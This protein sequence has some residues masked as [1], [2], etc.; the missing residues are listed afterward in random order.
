MVIKNKNKKDILSNIV[1]IPKTQKRVFWAREFKILND[2][3]NLFP[4][5]SFW[6][7]I[8]FKEKKD[9]LIF[10]K[11]E[12]GIKVLKTLYNEYNYQPRVT[13]K[14]ELGEKFGE[15]KIVSS[16]RNTIKNFLS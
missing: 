11:S 15:D 9:S 7:L 14:I 16:N 10:Y 5:E 3:M 4:N 8:N 13:P 6:N 12:H 1:N 2:L